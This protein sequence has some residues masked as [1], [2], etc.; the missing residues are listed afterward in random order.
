MPRTHSARGIP[1][2]GVQILLI[3]PVINPITEAQSTYFTPVG[4]QALLASLAE[5]GISSAIYTP[6]ILIA[7]DEDI[8]EV[9][10]DIL[11]MNPA[12]IGFSTWCDSFPFSLMIAEEIR[13]ENSTIPIIFGGPQASVLSEDKLQQYP[14][15]DFIL[16]GEADRSLP[17]LLKSLLNGSG[18]RHEAI[19]GLLFRNEEN[20]IVRQSS[21]LAIGDLDSLPIPSYETI[22]HEGMVRIDAGRGCPYRCSY[23]STNQFFSRKFRVKSVQRLIKEFNYCEDKLGVNWIGIS[24]DMFTLD[25]DF[26]LD[27]SKRLIEVN[28]KRRKPYYW[29]CSS[30]ADCVTEEIL[31]VMYESGCRAIFFGMETGSPRIQKE[32]RKNLNLDR[33]ARIIRHSAKLGI[34]TVVSYMMGFPGETRDDLMKTL[35]SILRESAYGAHTQLTM[36]SLLPGTPVYQDHKNELV[37]DG[38]H[39]PFSK[40]YSTAQ[41][42][43][44][45]NKDPEIFSSF[46]HLPNKNIPRKTY[47]FISELAN[48]LEHFVLTLSIIRDS[49]LQE[50]P[51]VDLY[52]YIQ[53]QVKKTEQK[54]N[55]PIPELF[56]LTES[57]K[58]YLERLNDKG[59]PLYA[60]DVFHLDFTKAFMI[61]KYKRWQLLNAGTFSEPDK[62]PALGP[63]TLLEKRPYWSIVKSRHY[64]YDYLQAPT[65]RRDLVKFRKGT[66]HYL[67]LPVSHRLADILKI[68]S[69]ELEIY[70]IVEGSSVRE[71]VNK[72]KGILREDRILRIIRRMYRLGLIDIVE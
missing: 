62:V 28:K 66:Y 65:K 45:I 32:I 26:I 31:D 33:A 58:H 21:P 9:A 53:D 57:I 12:T 14:F 11:S 4:L 23:C 49:L 47:L 43:S 67:V 72:N 61:S 41:I 36:L 15:I 1:E 56:F 54:K 51:T 19:P 25:K 16:Q 13:K 59:L 29:T 30:R 40:I 20:K 46:Y 55:K 42:E 22:Q 70:N 18:I 50:L 3:P 71:I 27:F 63:D 8:D 52:P 38:L 5:S 17:D 64:L 69:R 37:Y 44:M 48:Y 24:H 35:N 60:W 10:R 34:Y 39:S 68:P 2:T 6:H 7:R